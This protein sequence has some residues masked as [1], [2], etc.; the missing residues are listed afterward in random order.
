MVSHQCGFSHVSSNYLPVWLSC[1][2]LEQLNGFS[3]MWILLCLCKSRRL[4]FVDTLWTAEW[5]LINVY[6][7]TYLQMT[8]F[9]EII[10]TYWADEW[11]LIR[12]DPIMGLQSTWYGVCLITLWAAVWF[13]ICVDSLV[14]LQMSWSW[15]LVVTLWTYK[16]LV[17]GVDFFMTV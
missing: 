1:H 10:F 3:S 4:E 9:T 13:L 11:F 17:T 16:W 2:T 6:A 12:K 7:F 15:A 8:C 5:F 14:S